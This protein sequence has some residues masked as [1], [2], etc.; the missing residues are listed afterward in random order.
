MTAITSLF[1]ANNKARAETD[2]PT[3]KVLVNVLNFQIGMPSKQVEENAFEI[4]S[5]V[6]LLGN[7]VLLIVLVFANIS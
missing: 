1:P 5:L 6:P 2:Y 3:D 4:L 7:L